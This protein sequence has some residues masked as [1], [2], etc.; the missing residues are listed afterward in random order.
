VIENFHPKELWLGSD[1]QTSAMR[2][3]RSVAIANHVQ[4]QRRTAGEEFDWAGVHIQVLSPP[5]EW[6]AQR[7]PS[8][9]DSLTLLVGYGATKMLLAGEVEKEMESFVSGSEIGADVLKV[10]HHGSNSSTSEDLLDAV[11][12][13]FA[14]I[15]VGAQNPYGDPHPDVL[16]RLQESGAVTYRTDTMGAVTFLLDGNKIETRVALQ[17]K[18]A[19]P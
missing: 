5:Q 11:H 1:P 17:P 16:E 12:P 13:R 6:V 15:S 14:V 19:A 10:P 18:T 9:D 8:G 2:R 3:L 7:K 4:M